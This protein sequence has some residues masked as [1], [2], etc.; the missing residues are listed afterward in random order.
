MKEMTSTNSSLSNVTVPTFVCSTLLNDLLN[1]MQLLLQDEL[2]DSRYDLAWDSH[3]YR[4]SKF[5]S[6]QER[7]HTIEFR[8]M[9]VNTL[10]MD[11]H[12]HRPEEIHWDSDYQDY[13]V[14]NGDDNPDESK[15]VLLKA[16]EVMELSMGNIFKH[17]KQVNYSYALLAMALLL[18][19]YSELKEYNWNYNPKKELKHLLSRSI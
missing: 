9:Y 6:I 3:N 11:Y 15:A 1:D 4:E 18:K 19:I 10:I 7:D 8:L 14:C 17:G 16:K 2:A 5:M 13:Y 12:V